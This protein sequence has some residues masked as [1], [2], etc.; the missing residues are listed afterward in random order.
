MLRDFFPAIVAVSILAAA[1]ISTW[2]SD[3][4]S[5]QGVPAQAETLSPIRQTSSFEAAGLSAEAE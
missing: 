4:R 2:I 1:V 5:R 3:V